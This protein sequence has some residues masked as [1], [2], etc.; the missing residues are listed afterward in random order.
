M[1]VLV[2]EQVGS[3]A[4]HVSALFT[5]LPVSHLR[6]RHWGTVRRGENPPA[7]HN[8]FADIDFWDCNRLIVCAGGTVW[9]GVG[10]ILPTPA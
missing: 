1:A 2:A 10:Y 8:A 9:C 3:Q 7:H 5:C 4:V 6:S